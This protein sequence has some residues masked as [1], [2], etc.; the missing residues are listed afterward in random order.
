MIGYSKTSIPLSSD[1]IFAPV[2]NSIAQAVNQIPKTIQKTLIS[3]IN[4][5]LKML[6]DV[7]AQE[8]PELA[9]TINAVVKDGKLFYSMDGDAAPNL[10]YGNL[11]QAPRAFLRKTAERTARTLEQRIAKV[12]RL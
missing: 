7:V 8:N 9:K 3:T 11:E 2:S 4:N 5:D 12:T 1:P 10:E 6:R